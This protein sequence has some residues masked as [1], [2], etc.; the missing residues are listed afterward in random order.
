MTTAPSRHLRSWGMIALL[1]T[2]TAPLACL[3]NS[4]GTGTGGSGGSGGSSTGTSASCIPGAMRA[5][6]TGPAGTQ[7]KGQCKAG[8]QICNSD[9]VTFGQCQGEIVPAGIDNCNTL[10]EDENCDGVVNDNCTCEPGTIENCY[11]GPVTTENIGICHGGT[12]TC[13]GSGTW[14]SCNGEVLPGTEDCT[15]TADEDCDGEVFPDTSAGCVCDP[16]IPIVPCDTGVLGAC[17]AGTQG[18]AADGKSLSACVQSVQPVIED[19]ATP[20]DENCDGT[21]DCTGETLGG[22]TGVPNTGADDVVFATARDASGNA[23]VGGVV[24]G[25]V[26]GYSVFTGDLFLAK[27]SRDDGTEIWEQ[28]F[29]SDGHAVARS[30]AVDGMGNVIAVGHFNGLLDFAGTMF[31]S[32]DSGQSTDLFVVKL[33]AAGAVVWAKAIGDNSS[34]FAVA[35][36][37]D[38]AG[39]IYLT[40]GIQGTANFG[41]GSCNITSAG[42]YD[43]FVAKLNAAGTC[44]WGKKY[45]D[46]NNDQFGWG[47]AAIPGGEVAVVGEFEGA[48]NFGAGLNTTSLGSSDVFVMRIKNTDGNSV[49][50]KQFGDAGYQT[51]YSVAADAQGANLVVAGAFDGSIDFGGGALTNPNVGTDDIFVAKLAAGDGAFG[52]GKRFGGADDQTPTRVAFDGL[53]NVLLVGDYQGTFSFGGGNLTNADA[54]NTT[55]DAF[56]A[57]LTGTGAFLW[58]RSLGDAADQRAW[59]VTTDALG[60]VIVGGG[61]EGTTNFGPPVGSLTSPGGFY[62]VFTIRLKP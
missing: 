58:S 61:F 41:G 18:C 20:T 12:R 2:G 8:S 7:D 6:Y 59:D 40:G 37:V 13:S 35:V 46:A 48:A 10:E 17:S 33:D 26:Q 57:K 22:A 50:A 5:C 45:G 55:R 52:F 51:A 1:A 54:G 30:V 9:G 34:Q 44:Q 19:C 56:V 43:V 42:G 31:T 16:A 4:H 3:F 29:P 49:W 28:T 36:T 47:I 62:D 15:T 24:N 38:A 27:Y 25:N 32:A 53:G 14:G 11:T 39:D 60:N 21:D 23:V